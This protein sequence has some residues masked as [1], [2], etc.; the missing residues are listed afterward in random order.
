M[1]RRYFDS[2]V[3]YSLSFSLSLKFVIMFQRHNFL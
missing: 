3:E 1:E 2:L